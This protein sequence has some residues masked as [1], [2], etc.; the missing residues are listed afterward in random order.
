MSGLFE[1][2]T[3]A[4]RLR[5]Y[6][7]RNERL[8]PQAARLLEEALIRGEFE[9]GEAP[10]I[11]GLP[12]RSARRIFNEVIAAG[13]LASETP[14]GAGVATLSC[15]CLGHPLSSPI[16]R[17]LTSPCYTRA[18]S[19]PDDPPVVPVYQLMASPVF[20]E[21][22]IRCAGHIRHALRFKQMRLKPAAYRKG[23]LFA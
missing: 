18:A 19:I 8:K 4:R 17:N 7:E 6:V 11:T 23:F 16:P 12:E 20:T 3:L 1:L 15:R 13:L 10:R 9:R 14:E 5:L 2:D 21:A 22:R